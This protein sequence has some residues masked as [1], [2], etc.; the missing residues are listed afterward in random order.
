GGAPVRDGDLDLALRVPAEPCHDAELEQ[1]QLYVLCE[2][3]G[4][5]RIRNL[6][7]VARKDRGRSV[8]GE[9]RLEEHPL[10]RQRLL[11]DSFRDAL[12]GACHTGEI[13]QRAPANRIE[14]L[15]V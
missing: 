1:E 4:I 5:G 11:P 14:L 6:D 2:L 10:E 15:D 3:L 9:E 7:R 8:T 13:R 12:M